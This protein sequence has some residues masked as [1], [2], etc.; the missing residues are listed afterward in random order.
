LARAQVGEIDGHHGAEA[1][2][3]Q[4]VPQ[5]PEGVL[6]KNIIKL[7]PDLDLVARLLDAADADDVDLRQGPGDALAELVRGV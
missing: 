6:D 7:E 2:G 3:A 5:I 4:D 1:D